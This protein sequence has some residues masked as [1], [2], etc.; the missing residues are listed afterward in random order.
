MLC[1]VRWND[2]NGM[3]KTIVDMASSRHVRMLIS[4]SNTAAEPARCR[5]VYIYCNYSGFTIIPI[6]SALYYWILNCCFIVVHA[7][8]TLT[9]RNRQWMFPSRRVFPAV[10]DP[11]MIPPFPPPPPP[12]PPARSV[13]VRRAQT[14]ES[15]SLTTGVHPH[16]IP[17][18]TDCTMIII[19]IIIYACGAV[20]W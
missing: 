5:S 20:F 19:I 18:Q 3:S 9:A 4:Y 6:R 2:R 13:R 14:E 16:N 7:R 8:R 11:W 10:R 17:Y 15:R 12:P 1:T